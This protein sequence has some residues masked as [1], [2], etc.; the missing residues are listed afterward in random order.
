MSERK[1]LP[2]MTGPGLK[3]EG[4][5]VLQTFFIALFTFLE[6]SIRNGAGFLSGIV[7]IAVTYGG[8]AY[9]RPGTRYVSAVTPPLAY[10]ATTL[11]YTILSVGLS[12]SRLGVDFIASLA[13]VAPYLLV[14]SIYGWFQFL[15]EKAKSRPS[16]ARSTAKA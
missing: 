5:V 12:I 4:V 14:A 1:K 9:G 15:N 10:A 3:K 16:K 6:L 2:V 11:T 13:S 8:I 7:L